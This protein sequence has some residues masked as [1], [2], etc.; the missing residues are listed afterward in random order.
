MNLVPL[1][2]CALAAYRAARLVAI[3][4]IT[5]PLR[6]AL[7]IRSGVTAANPSGRRPTVWLYGLLS[8]PHCLGVWISVGTYAAW[9]EAPGSS[10]WPITAAA[11]AGLQSLVTSFDKAAAQ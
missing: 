5:D 9:T 11:V 8:C 10:H 1:A 4:S 6:R 2:L 7:W 3:D